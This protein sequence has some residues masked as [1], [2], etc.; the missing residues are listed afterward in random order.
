MLQWALDE[1]EKVLGADHIGSLYHA[2]GKLEQAEQMDIRRITPKWGH[3]ANLNPQVQADAAG[4]RGHWDTDW[5]ASSHRARFAA[6]DD[7]ALA[8]A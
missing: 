3:N 7:R 8:L 1:C 2:Q 6:L 5:K 4:N